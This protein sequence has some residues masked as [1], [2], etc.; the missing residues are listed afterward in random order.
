MNSGAAILRAACDVI[1]RKYRFSA[2]SATA[3]SNIVSQAVLFDIATTSTYYLQWLEKSAAAR[4]KTI[5]EAIAD[6]DGAIDGVTKAIKEAS[7][8]LTLTSSTMQRV[9][10]ETLRC[11]ASA[12][13]ASGQ[14]TDKRRSDHDGDRR[15]FQ[16]DP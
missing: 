10:D 8:S 4:R 1:A 3:R 15:T 11:M 9:T 7:G 2:A 6:F 14:T 13:T 12:S 5:D 16:F